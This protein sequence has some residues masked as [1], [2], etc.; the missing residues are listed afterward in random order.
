MAEAETGTEAKAEAGA[1]TEADPAEERST[2]GA[3][4]PEVDGAEGGPGR[5]EAPR[6]PRE[7]G[8]RPS[9][10]KAPK[11]GTDSLHRQETLGTVQEPHQGARAK[12]LECA[13]ALFGPLT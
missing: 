10:L 8:L 5:F 13:D 2:E 12:A 1:S 4:G 11:T 3:E 9:G 7:P 6:P